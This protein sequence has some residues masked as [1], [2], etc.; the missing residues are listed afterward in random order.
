[1]PGLPEPPESPRS[2]DP[3]APSAVARLTDIGIK[4]F[5]TASAVRAIMADLRAGG[6]VVPGGPGTFSKSD[7]SRFLQSLDTAL[8]KL[9][10]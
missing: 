4:P 6:D 8:V 1:M 10:R 2:Q 9:R 3:D 5:L 7:R